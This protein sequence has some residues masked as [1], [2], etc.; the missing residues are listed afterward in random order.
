MLATQWVVQFLGT[1]KRQRLAAGSVWLEV[2]HCRVWLNPYSMSSSRPPGLLV[3]HVKHVSPRPPH[4]P[5][6]MLSLPCC[7]EVSRKPHHFYLFLLSYF[8]WV[9]GRKH[10]HYLE[11]EK[12]KPWPMVALL[13][14]ECNSEIGG[15]CL[16]QGNRKHPPM[17]ANAQC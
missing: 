16:S 7:P 14:Q 10:K 5:T 4:T 11:T 17:N 6:P 1:F 2:D 12:S 8:C 13:F 15:E 9:S 3:S